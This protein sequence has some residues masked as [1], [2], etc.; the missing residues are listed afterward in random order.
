MKTTDSDGDGIG[1]N[2]DPTPNGG[3]AT[4]LPTAPSNSTTIIVETSSGADRVWNVNPDNDSVSVVDADGA[5]LAE[6]AVG[7]KPWALAKSPG[8]DHVFVT[9]KRTATLSVIDTNTLAVVDSIALPF[10]SQPHGVAF[11]QLGT[12]YFVVLEA[13]AQV[14]Q[15]DASTH[16]VINSVQLT[17]KP[18]HLSMTPNDGQLLVSN[19]IT[20]PVPG[21]ST[22]TVD[23]QN[24]AAQVFVLDPSSLTLAST[25]AL[26]HDNRSLSESQ[27]PG[28][29]NYLHAPVVSFDGSYAYIPSKKDNIDSG[30][31]RGKPG[32]TFEFTVRA[33]ASRIAL[34]SGTEDN[35]FRVDFDNS[36]VATGAALTGDDRYLL[37]ALETSRELS[38]Y[39][40]VNNFELMRLPTGRAPQGVAL[41]SDGSRAYVH[42]FM[43]RSISRFDLTEMLETGLPATNLLTTVDVVTVESLGADVLRG[44]EL[45]YDALDDRLARDNYMS[46]ASCHNDGADDGRVWD[47]GAFGEGLR[48]TISLNGRGTGHGPLHWTGNFDEVQDF[49]GQIRTLALGTGLMSDTDFANT[50]DPLGNPK[51]GLSVDLDNLAAYVNSLTTMPGSPHRA[52]PAS[53]DTVAQEGRSLFASKGCVDCHAGASFTDSES[54][55]LH[56]VGTIGAGSGDRLGLP[57][58]GFDTPT[59]LGIWNSPPYLHDGSAATIAEA[60]ERHNGTA[61]TVDDVTKL[62]AYL[63]QANVGDDIAP[64]PD[65]DGDGVP[66]VEDAFP[67]DPTE[68]ADSDGDGVGDNADAFP[69]DPAETTDSDGDGVGD[70]SDAFPNDPNESADSDGDGVG[71]NTDAFPNDPAETTDSD[72]DGV[73][74]NSDAFPND[75]NESADSD[76]D[77]VGD[78]AGR[79]PQ[80]SGR[81]HRLR[82]RRRRR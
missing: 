1:D 17:G 29:P 34:A 37:V 60:I 13:L 70:N 6:I 78:N 71:D 45:F 64:L 7:G 16:A 46:C 20:P 41:S 12:S 74:D 8:T 21:E 22:T 10:D 51:T 49:E 62:A 63:R 11:N 80:R 43:D 44:K 81:D 56:D 77:G 4:P 28:L 26:S 14:Q 40:T 57:L 24:G 53:M 3:G 18:R 19:F 33:N 75:P 59:V 31:L 55:S 58:T 61:L 23:V 47:L 73:G 15:R 72:G 39:D 48:K 50:N 67:N 9:N 42:N 79:V 32:M 38:V 65:S 27:G 66:D 68:T 54:G 5:L 52:S 2:S 69:N 25:I 36:S 30:A 82:R 76:G 35:V